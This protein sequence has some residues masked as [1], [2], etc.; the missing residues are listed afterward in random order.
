MEVV[1]LSDS[2]INTTVNRN[3]IG[4]GGTITI[5]TGQL[6]MGDRSQ[7]TS[8]TAGQGDSGQVIVT[9]SES[10]FLSGNSEI[11]T[12]VRRNATGDSQQ[13]VLQTPELTLRGN[14]QISAATLGDGNAGSIDISGADTV[15]LTNSSISTAINRNGNAT[16]PSNITLDTRSLQ[17]NNNANITAS[18]AGQGNAGNITIENAE[19]VSLTGSAIASEVLPTARGRGGTLN[20]NANL[21]NLSDQ[22]SITAS[23]QGRGRAGDI[24]ITGVDV[25][26]DRASQI[27]STTSRNR[28]AGDITIVTSNSVSLDGN[29]TGIFANTE[30]NSTGDGG[31]IAV[32][33]QHLNL[34]N[35]AEISS[36]SLGEGIA[37]NIDIQADEKLQLE[38][39]RIATSATQSAG[40]AIEIVAGDIF[41][42]GTSDIITS[43][44]SGVDSGGNI[45]ISA[46]DIRL[47]DDSD[48][49]T[50]VSGGTGDGGNIVVSANSIIAFDDSDIISSA[51]QGRG[52]DITLD[53]AA[54]FGE[55]FNPVSFEAD[56]DTLEGNDRADI[57]ATGAVT[58]TVALP[59]TSFIQNSLSDLPAGLIN[60]EALIANSCVARNEDGSSTFVITGAGGLPLR[61]GDLAPSPYPTGEVRV[62]PDDNSQSW[63]PGDPIIEPDGVYQLPN[64]ELILS[65][66]CR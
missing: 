6:E 66:Q 62:V 53:T 46:N 12:A 11:T 45:D 19:E 17:L 20:I 8:S 43:V 10:I 4:Q 22:S 57:N 64:G 26:G 36:E 59:D 23:T 47:R 50:N 42:S 52:G 9:A 14:S 48:I 40:G 18:T 13:I 15:R 37:G 39:G 16:E 63:Q 60:T 7:L 25:N 38:N 58:G 31:N 33:T 61:P 35:R 65:H 5:Q 2:S 49:R 54:Y 44:E 24:F 34:T 41:L 55:N 32:H 21:L 56:P 3:G 30:Q 1:F 28:D 51:P 29:S 27:R